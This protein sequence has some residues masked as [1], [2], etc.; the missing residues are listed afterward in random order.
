MTQQAANIQNADPV[1]APQRLNK[2]TGKRQ[3]SANVWLIQRAQVTQKI[4]T[5]PPCIITQ[6]LQLINTDT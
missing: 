6:N 3:S 5:V 4:I 1:T 2:K